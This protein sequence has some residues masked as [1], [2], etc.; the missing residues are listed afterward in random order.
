MEHKN[1]LYHNEV[2]K[3]TMGMGHLKIGDF[4]IVAVNNGPM[5]SLSPTE[6]LTLQSVSFFMVKNQSELQ[7]KSWNS[8]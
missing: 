4:S 5:I 7:L 6:R 2:I 8:R 1:G 3:E